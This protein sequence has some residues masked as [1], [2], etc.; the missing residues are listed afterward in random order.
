MET[1]KKRKMV[2][3]T[4]PSRHSLVDLII[5]LKKLA[6][7]DKETIIAI[8]ETLG[9]SFEHESPNLEHSKDLENISISPKEVYEQLNSNESI[10]P[11]S[12]SEIPQSNIQRSEI[13]SESDKSVVPFVLTPPEKSEA[14]LPAW[15]YNPLPLKNIVNP[16]DPNP[17]SPNPR[18]PFTSYPLLT[19]FNPI[20]TRYILVSTLSI[21]DNVGPLDIGEILRLVSRNEPIKEIPRLPLLTMVHGVQVL[22]D[23][24]ETLEP[25][26][27]DQINLK[28]EIRKIA[29]PDRVQILGFLGC[30]LRGVRHGIFDSWSEYRPPPR[31]TTVLLLTD[32]GILRDPCILDHVEVGEWLRFASIIRKAG[33][34]LVAFVPYPKERWPKMLQNSIRIIQ[35]DRTTVTPRILQIKKNNV[36]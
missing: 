22:I 13:F 1:R 6:P 12:P 36:I 7:S 8:M 2:A 5:T 27:K 4:N 30:P 34:S 35:W 16:K 33:C 14:N 24:S 9:I 21:F 29:G 3:F 28:R 31:R 19:L 23:E 20:L 17:K 25:F 18:N 11:S 32:L 15:F 10:L 26:N